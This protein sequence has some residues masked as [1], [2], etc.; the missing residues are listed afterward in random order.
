[1]VRDFEREQHTYRPGLRLRGLR[2]L[3]DTEIELDCEGME[4]ADRTFVASSR[5][6]VQVG[7]SSSR[8]A[9]RRTDRAHLRLVGDRRAESVLCAASAGALDAVVASLTVRAATRPDG[10]LKP[11]S[12]EE[13]RAARIEGWIAL[14][15]GSLDDLRPSS[16]N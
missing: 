12:T 2:F 4:T 1:M 6:Q 15:K 16:D 9:A 8:V 7:F 11:G 13:E 3:S 10:W 5:G 14:P